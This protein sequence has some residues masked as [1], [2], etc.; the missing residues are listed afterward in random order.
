MCKTVGI[1]ASVKI[2]H[3]VMNMAVN[4]LSAG[5]LLSGKYELL[6]VLGRGGFGI[7][8]RARRLDGGGPAAIKEF[9]WNGH[10]QRGFDGLCAEPVAPEE[11]EDVRGL[12]SRFLREARVL[13]SFRDEPALVRVDDY[14][15]E[16]GT[17]YIVME[18]LE[19]KTLE[20]ELR[21]RGSMDAVEL[22]RS[23]L[24]VLDCL[25]RIHESGWIHRD[26]SPDNLML[27]PDGSLK[28]LDFGAVKRYEESR[29]RKNSYYQKSS[30][31]P[32][33]QYDAGG[34]LGPW[35]DIYSL[36]ASLYRC[37]TGLRPPD[38]LV[39]MRED[40]MPK[41][42]ELGV[43][44][45]P[46]LE[47][48]LMKGMALEPGRR[49]RSAPE[50]KAALEA[51]LPEKLLEKKRRR[52]KRF[53]LLCAAALMLLCAAAG[54]FGL[55]RKSDPLFGMETSEFF[56]YTLDEVTERP[57]EERIQLLIPEI[58]ALT[59]G[60]YTLEPLG[61]GWL[62]TVPKD[63]LGEDG[64]AGAAGAMLANSQLDAYLGCRFVPDAVW[65]TGDG[66][67]GENQCRPEDFTEPT[68]L[69]LFEN[70]SDDAVDRAYEAEMESYVKR[71]LDSLDAPYAY[72][73]T[74]DGGSVVRI[75]PSR[76]NGVVEQSL[77]G[78]CNVSVA[79]ADTRESDLSLFASS[80]ALS[81]VESEPG[82]YALRYYYADD[83]LSSA[84]ELRELLLS[85]EESEVY[86]SVSNITGN[87]FAGTYYAASAS[88][89]A[90]TEEG[91][92]IFDRLLAGDGELDE[93]SR[94]TLD[95]LCECLNAPSTMA[96]LKICMAVLLDES[97]EPLL[98][99]YPPDSYG[100]EF[101]TD[102]FTRSAKEYAR[103]LDEELPYE[104]GFK[105]GAIS[106][107]L[108]FSRDGGQLDEAL[109]AACRLISEQ[110]DFTGRIDLTDTAVTYLASD[111]CL[112]RRI[113]SGALLNVYAVEDGRAAELYADSELPDTDGLRRAWEEL[114]L[115]EGVEKGE[116]TIYDEPIIGSLS[117]YYFLY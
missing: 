96:E 14:F 51:A 61:E 20:Q 75:P 115:P 12:C 84:G 90:Q 78:P 4:S 58:E 27:L 63:C 18:L 88:A 44:I 113:D 31:S 65:E 38:S 35:T 69:L 42:S 57:L 9:F 59:G 53:G 95:Y 43:S 17:A 76:V 77:F 64:A 49:W 5:T 2:F 106:V 86:I 56:F 37:I 23:V 55:L 109:D 81:V 111:I 60:L 80:G 41:P 22:T 93:D 54:L 13:E 30:F 46:E 19:G 94:W 68:V 24:P 70:T 107:S 34:E 66:A 89:G 28:L 101:H 73:K 91:A 62:L 11:A 50:L 104:V 16:N 8:Y 92:L 25:G 71:R 21:E 114:A 29:L 33:E 87:L 6:S 36:C 15:E 1:E 32:P 40:A 52:R 48:A 72:G 98:D 85:G 108:G 100:L 97:G 10:M 99:A 3:L 26:I 7:T 83:I 105:L 45:S 102:L 82:K 67:F 39:R 74:S 117:E 79:G 112:F 103:K 47:R 110:P 116:F